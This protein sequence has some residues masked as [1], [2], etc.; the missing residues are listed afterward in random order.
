MSLLLKNVHVVDVNS[1]V[2][3]KQANILIENGK[4]AS[5]KGRSAKKEIDLKGKFLSC[6]WF[7]LSAQFNDPGNEHREDIKSGSAAAQ[8]GG[9]TDVCMVP[10]TRPPIE[11]KS[12]V[13]YLLRRSGDE[14]D[15]HVIAAISEGLEGKNLTEVLDLHDAGAI[16]FSDGDLP[17]WNAE[18]LLKALQYTS[19]I[20]LPIMQNARDMHISSNTHMHEG[21]MSTH[22]GLR[23]EPSLSEELMIRRDLD[24]LKYSGGSIH[25]SRISTEKA[26]GLI[27]E[28]KKKGLSV[29]CDV[30][31]HHLV[32]TDESVGDFDTNFKSLPP[33]RTERDRRALIKGVKEGVIEAIC[34]NHRPYDQECKQLEFDLADPGNTSLQTFYSSLLKISKEIP[35]ELLID[36]VV[37]GPRKVLKKELIRIDEGEEAKLTIFD[38][39]QTWV[40]NDESN[41]SKSRNSPYWGQEMKGKVLGTINKRS[42]TIE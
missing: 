40:L 30:G 29:T 31:I 33:Y 8:S 10:S 12:D 38:P 13:N 14:V 16:A 18:L 15:I 35:I 3:G 32:F 22:L 42:I 7:D 28:A 19:D 20:G 1:P 34:S 26:V 4:I 27:K 24:I 39:S 9:F 2:H 41:R 5:L 36:R 23:G 17:V 21:R 25:F 6:G 37:N 11:S